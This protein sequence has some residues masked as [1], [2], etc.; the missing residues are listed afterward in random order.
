[1]EGQVDTTWLKL[2]GILPLKYAEEMETCLFT[3]G[4]NGIQTITNEFLPPGETKLEDGHAKLVMYLEQ[5]QDFKNS[6]VLTIEKIWKDFLQKHDLVELDYLLVIE[7]LESN[8][9]ATSWK[10]FFHPLKVGKRIWISPSWEK[11]E[12]SE[13]EIAI[14]I[15]PGMAFGTGAHESTALLIKALERKADESGL[16][17]NIIDVGC[18]SGVLSILA[19][20]LGAK[21]LV[22]IDIDPEAVRISEENLLINNLDKNS[23]DISGTVIEKVQE[24]YPLVLANMISSILF[25]IKKDLCRITETGGELWLSGLLD[26]EAEEVKN[27]FCSEGMEFIAKDVMGEWASL[28]LRKL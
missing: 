5:E 18:G 20:K 10:K 15:D 19:L 22:G 28:R 23:Y 21:K 4:V 6:F 24:K 26:E 13:N 27:E 2:S 7:D 3:L 16:P 17:V 25:S 1:M 12:V 11:A 14:E 9:W 8:D